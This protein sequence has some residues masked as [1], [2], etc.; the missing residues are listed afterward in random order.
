MLCLLAAQQ[1]L[2]VIL[3][4]NQ[5]FQILK[6]P[7]KVLEGLISRQ[8]KVQLFEVNHPILQIYSYQQVSLF[9]SF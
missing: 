5:E 3:L 6:F 1:D 2:F 8:I 7:F 4:L 9:S